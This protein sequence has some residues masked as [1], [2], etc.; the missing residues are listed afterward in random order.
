[1]KGVRRIDGVVVDGV[2]EKSSAIQAIAEQDSSK[3]N[4]MEYTIK[5]RSF[6]L[7]KTGL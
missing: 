1:M 6:I 4:L 3:A 7:D 2:D 5:A